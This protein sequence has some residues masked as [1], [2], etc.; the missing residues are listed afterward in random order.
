VYY[1]MADARIGVARVW[2]R[3]EAGMEEG[4]EAA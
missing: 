2:L 3:P 4:T 1:G